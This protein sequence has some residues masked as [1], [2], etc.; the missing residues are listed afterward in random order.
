MTTVSYPGVY[1]EEIPGGARPI[2][3]AGTSTAA[4]VGEAEKGPD[5]M[6]VRITSWDEY[7]RQFGSFI[8]DC[9]LAQSVYAFFNNGGRQCYIVRVTRSDATTASVTV[10]NRANIDHCVKFTAKN[11]GKWGNYIFFSIED[12]KN[13]HSN[14]FKLTLYR[15]TDPVVIPENYAL[16]PLEVHDNLS[17]DPDAP[18]YVVEV[19]KRDSAILSAEVLEANTSLQCGFHL[20]GLNP[21]LPMAGKNKFQ[22]SLD[23]DGFQE[24]TLTAWDNL[25]VVATNITEKVKALTPKKNSNKP[26]FDDFTCTVLGDSKV[27]T[28]L[29]LQSGTNLPGKTPSKNS[30][31]Q[32]Q[33]S[34]NNNAAESLKLGLGNG[35]TGQNALAVRRPAIP[36]GTP[37][38]IQLGD[39]VVTGVVTAAIQGSD[40]TIPVTEND[41]SKAFS[42][43]DNK[44]DFS[45]LAV[46]GVGTTTMLNSGMV[47]CQN[48]PL[49]DVFYIGEMGQYDDQ[50][51]EA[52]SFRNKPIKANSY[53]AVYFP[54]VKAPDPAGRSPSP[55]PLPPSGFIAGLYARIDGSRGVWKAPAGIEAS[56]NGVVGLTKELT[57]TEQGNLNPINVNVIRRFSLAGVVSWGA[58]TITAD[59]EYKYIPVRRTAIML[60]RSIYDGI[61]WAVFEPNDERLWSALRLNIG[62]F[63]NSLFRA[64]AF[65]GSKASDAYF[66]RCGLGDTMV[67][68]DIDRGQV[69]V[70]VGFAPLKP[71]EFVIVRIQ[72]KAGQQ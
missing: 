18:N 1:V 48:R 29:L 65:Q 38:V 61:Q 63:M 3:A 57:D 64:G 12:G 21:G 31:V 14:E 9:Y 22:I 53:G 67:Q 40:G 24:I 59:P 72:Q 4:F 47:Y 50:P 6:A 58:R 62:S 17:M 60:R 11:K 42:R 20:S 36:T 52:E 2:E 26:A 41:F 43:L 71:A 15:Q 25:T 10:K 16:T 55:I 56:L 69:I 23:G 39:A 28:Y 45:L 7:Q 35:G 49:Q 51:D 19:L 13:D 37:S 66:V 46:P 44:S 34:P 68:D 32:I 70:L 54:W 27:G 5:D 30:A 8:D 33:N